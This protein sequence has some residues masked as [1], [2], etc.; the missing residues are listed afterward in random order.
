MISLNF[1]CVVLSSNSNGENRHP[2]FLEFMIQGIILDFF[3]RGFTIA[4]RFTLNSLD[5]LIQWRHGGG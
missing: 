1:Y 2:V 4:M 5:D 3:R